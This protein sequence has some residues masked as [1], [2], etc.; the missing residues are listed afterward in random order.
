MILLETLSFSL[1][2][3][4]I[5]SPYKLLLLEEIHRIAL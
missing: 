1:K 2:E 3:Q 4:G 5:L